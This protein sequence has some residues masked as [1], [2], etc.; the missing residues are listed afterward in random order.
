MR[1]RGGSRG[2]GLG[3]RLLQRLRI[4]SHR[5]RWLGALL[6]GLKRVLQLE[7]TPESI[8]RGVALGLVIAFTPTVG[9]QMVLVLIIHTLARANRLAGIAM[10]WLTNPLTVVPVYWWDYVLGSWLLARPRIPLERFRELFALEQTGFFAQFFEFLRNVGELGL[11]VLG[12][13]AL[14]GLLTGLALALPAYPLT[15]WLVRQERAALERLRRLRAAR[16]ARLGRRARRPACPVP[17]PPPVGE[18][19]VRG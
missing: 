10:V 8:A 15:L 17:P 3:R 19:P 2:R 4:Q 1:R 9:I 6:G 7:D 13:M 14:G 11:D 5:W 18:E 12:P 16:R